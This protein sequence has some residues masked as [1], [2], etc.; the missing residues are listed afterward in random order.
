MHS[1][2]AGEAPRFRKQTIVATALSPDHSGDLSHTIVLDHSGPSE[3]EV[4]YSFRATP[5]TK[6]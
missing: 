6:S 3:V 2:I 5:P 4:R 1:T